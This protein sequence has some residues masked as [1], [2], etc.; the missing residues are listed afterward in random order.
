MLGFWFWFQCEKNSRVDQMC[1]TTLPV[2]SVTGRT[3]S[4]QNIHVGSNR[5]RIELGRVQLDALPHRHTCFTFPHSDAAVIL[6]KRVSFD[7]IARRA[8]VSR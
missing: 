4:A 2:A 1:R 5:Q 6:S 7:C 8:D 3:L